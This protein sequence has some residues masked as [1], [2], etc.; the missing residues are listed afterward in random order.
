MSDLKERL[1]QAKTGPLA[2]RSSVAD[3]HEAADRIEAL[4]AEVER[5]TLS[6][7]IIAERAEEV[8]RD[9]DSKKLA[10]NEVFDA[11]QGA[12]RRARNTLESPS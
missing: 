12:G 7:T 6:L 3:M 2:V 9:R 4:E 11:F 5:M 10:P 8:K 1:R